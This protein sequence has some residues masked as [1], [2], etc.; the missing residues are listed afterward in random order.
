M[1]TSESGQL[2]QHFNHFIS[3]HNLLE[4]PLIVGV[5]GGLDSMVLLHLCKELKLDLHVVHVNYQKRGADSDADQHLIEQFCKTNEL[6]FTVFTAPPFFQGNFQHEARKYRFQ[7]FHIVGQTKSEE[8]KILLAHHQNDQAETILHRI[9]KGSSWAMWRAMSSEQGAVFRPLLKFDK[10]LLHQF[11]VENRINWRE[12][13]SNYLNDFDRNFLRNKIIQNLYKRYPKTSKNIIQIG[14]LSEKYQI[15]LEEKLISLN[16]SKNVLSIQLWL[17]AQDAIKEDILSLWLHKNAP[18]LKLS[19]YFVKEL[20]DKMCNNLESTFSEYLSGNWVIHFQKNMLYIFNLSVF[21][22]AKYIDENTRFNHSSLSGVFQK[23]NLKLDRV[24]KNRVDFKST[25]KLFLDKSF[26]NELIH[27]R[28]MKSGD[29]FKQLGMHGHQKKVVDLLA[30]HEIP[31]PLRPYTL[32]LQWKHEILALVFPFS[33][34]YKPAR[35]GLISEIGKV[36]KE[37]KNVLSLS[38]N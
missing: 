3:H 34:E 10:Q 36:K 17:Q 6:N 30:E 14:H 11:A 2:I 38:Q 32:V 29:R 16:S 23:L 35:L 9:L 33:S 22:Y 28:C 8:Y 21:T 37:S 19:A 25:T 24:E 12:D 31:T 27:I 4:S 7:C 1:K 15:L 26:E 13:S 18:E 5:S 20:I